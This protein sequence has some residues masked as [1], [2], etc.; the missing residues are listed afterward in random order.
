MKKLDKARAKVSFYTLGCRANQYDTEA[1]KER[2]KES[3]KL[4][5]FEEEADIYVI[6]TCTVTVGADRKARKYIRRAKRK[7]GIVLVTGCYPALN[8]KEIAEMEAAD[9]VF[10]NRHKNHLPEIIEQALNGRRGLLQGGGDWDLEKESIR[11]DSAH[12][13]AFL[14]VQDGCDGDCTFCKIRYVRGPARSKSPQSVLEEVRNLLE[15]GFR[16]IVL[17]GI[18]LASYEWNEVSLP[19]L[20]RRIAQV[21]GVRRIRLSSLNLK[22]MTSDLLYLFKELEEPCPHFHISLQ[23][24]SGRVLKKMGRKYDLGDFLQT[25][26]KFRNELPQATFGADIM[27]GF[28]G[29]REEDLKETVKAVKEARLINSHVF[30]YSPRSET[31]ASK[32]EVTIGSEEKKRRSDKLRRVARSVALTEKK[33]F[34]EDTFAVMLEEPSSKTAGW[35]GLT[36]NYLDVHLSSTEEQFQE[37]EVVKAKLKEVH[38]DHFRG[39][40]IKS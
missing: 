13:R 39:E 28:P 34:L 40:L 18:D 27:V 11:R 3:F 20:M 31:P 32:M 6:N 9:L 23:S 5:S 2:L 37:G 22:G 10:D 33:N 17:T 36:R 35:R 38:G 30:R 14:K 16:E 7:G 4:V 29:E 12:T 26:D 8:G 24:G 15:E 1:M 19:G 21:E 25:V